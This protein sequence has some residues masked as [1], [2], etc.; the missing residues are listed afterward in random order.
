MD[1]AAAAAPPAEQVLHAVG[2]T[3][4]GLT[5]A[6]CLGDQWIPRLERR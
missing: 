3:P 5:Q 4:G 6:Q 2:T 1:V